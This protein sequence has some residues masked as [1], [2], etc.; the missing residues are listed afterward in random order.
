ML[1]KGICFWQ[2]SFLGRISEE[3]WNYKIKS[4]NMMVSLQT[5]KDLM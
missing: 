4:S 1:K 5:C 3:Y 2:M